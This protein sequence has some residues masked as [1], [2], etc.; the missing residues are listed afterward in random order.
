MLPPGNVTSQNLI[1]GIY[2]ADAHAI[3]APD[4]IETVIVVQHATAFE[5]VGLAFDD[6][7][8]QLDTRPFILSIAQELDAEKAGLQTLLDHNGFP[9]EPVNTI[10][11]I[12][13]I[14]E[15]MADLVR[16]TPE[17]VAQQPDGIG[18]TSPDT[19][20][21]SATL[22]KDGVTNSHHDIHFDSGIFASVVADVAAH[23]P[24]VGHDVVISHDATH[25]VAVHLNHLTAHDFI[26]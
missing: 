15:K 18:W 17:L 25:T 26:V 4:A 23:A 20:V 19:F 16:D 5:V 6:V 7:S 8:Q 9:A 11:K 21:F 12:E 22:A 10:A 2:T 3:G 13:H 24:E 1:D 14:Q